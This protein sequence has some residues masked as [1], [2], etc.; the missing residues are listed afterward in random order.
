MSD[1]ALSKGSFTLPG[2][3]GYEGLTM[4]LA[5]K[6]GAD[7]IRDSDG[8]KLSDTILGS[9]YDIYSTLCLVRADN[10]WA[11]ANRDK[12]QQNFLMSF[13]V[14]ARGGSLEI[15]ILD[16]YFREQFVV[17]ASEASR[18]YW[19]AFDRTTGEEVPPSRWRY[20]PATGKAR[21]E[22]AIAWH[23]YTVNFLVFRIWEEISMYNHI[24]NDWGDKEHLMSVEPRHPE[25]QAHLLELLEDWLEARPATKVVRFTSLFYNFCWFWGDRPGRRHVYSDWGSYDFTVN[26]LALA[27]FERSRGYRMTSEDF[28]NGGLYNASHNLPSRKYRDWMD[29]TNEFV[30]EFGKKCVKLVHD[31]GK[32][33]FLFYDDHWI[34]TEPY[35]ERFPELGLDGIIK[36]VFNGFEARLCAG[37]KGVKTRELRLHPYLFPTGLKGE[38]TFKEGG[39]PTLDAKRFWVQVR[40]ALLRAPVDRIGLGG[41]LHLVEGFPDFQDYIESLG[42][43]FRLLKSF[44][45]GDKPYV[46]PVKVGILSAWGSLRSWI[47]SGHLHEHPEVQLTNVLEALAGLPFEVEFLSF[48][49]VIAEGVPSGIGV[50]VNAGREGSAWS[51]GEAWN[52]AALVERVRA[53]VAGGGAFIGVG[54]PTA[55]RPGAPFFKLA[56]LLGVDREIG[57]TI[58]ANKYAY[59]PP[60]GRHFVVEE[61]S[62]SPNL[63][64]ETDGVF[65]VDGATE[66]LTE[67]PA[68][69]YAPASVLV[70]A[71]EYGEGRSLYLAGFAYSLENARLLHRAIAWCARKEGEFRKWSCEDYRLE[72][73]YYPGKRKLVVINDSDDAV[74]SRVF[75]G[76]GRATEVSIAAHGI[77]IIEK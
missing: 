74:A 48:D 61:L 68:A 77:S 76:E 4:K 11:K 1:D 31:Y 8:T 50:L 54:E 29:F 14:T 70:A 25:T 75:D 34:G 57:A 20:D 71:R 30:V 3:A 72:C 64:K 63:G 13:P 19:Q 41:Y 58:C 27:E 56:D 7:T 45:E 46:M 49:Q 66:V 60:S 53:W 33:A 36:C 23:S 18:A 17:D 28:V 44:H 21:I 62:A 51:G 2:E 40:R 22:G 26:P 59:S 55:S 5:A 9:G 65:A 69:P 47:C 67:R 52:E 24:T 15:D 10:E 37:V 16:G 39:N 6:W 73:A 38:P 12:L 42:R 35:G 32:K 43:E